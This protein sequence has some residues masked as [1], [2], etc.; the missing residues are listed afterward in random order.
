ML[1]YNVKTVEETIDIIKSHVQPISEV[2]TLPIGG[3]SGYILAEDIVSKENVPAF[4]RSTVDGYAVH[5]KDTFG[6]SESMPSFLTLTNEIKMGEEVTTPLGDGEAMYIPTGGM[7]PPGCDSIIM[8]EH[9]EDIDGLLNTYKEVAPGENIISVGEDVKENEILL[10]KGT[11]LRSQELGILGSVGHANVQVYR[12][13]IVGYLSSGDEI[14][15]YDTEQLQVGQ[16]RDINQLTISTLTKEA[17]ADLVNGGIVPDDY[18]SF[19]AK[20]KELYNQV[21]LLVMSGGSSVG[22]KDYTTDVIAALG[23]PGVLVNGVSVKPGKP[24]I[25]GMANQKPVLGLPGHPASAVIIYKLFGERLIHLLNG[26]TEHELPNAVEANLSQNLPSSP[27]RSDYIRVQLKN[28][29]NQW[30]AYP[31]LGKSGLISTLVESDGMVEIPS[32]KEGI[33]Q[34][35]VVSVYLFR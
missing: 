4:A 28:E 34:G 21:D 14:M 27:G 23:E 33:R 12:K 11:K 10:K 9:C 31:V 5:S 2:I 22:T 15:P 30:W 35:E 24:T 7:I 16:V 25:F 3:A 19:F 32:E 13:V 20:A 8:I 26:S 17:G 18:E 29:N 1:F 6:S